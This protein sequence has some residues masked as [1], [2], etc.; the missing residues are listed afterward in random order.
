MSD[1]LKAVQFMISTANN[2]IHGYDQTNRNS[3]DYDCSSL[4][5]TALY[6]A[7][8]KVS[9]YSWTGNLL[10]QLKSCGFTECKAPWQAGDV[11][12]NVKHH[13]CMSIN[14][15]QIVHASI[16]ELGKATGGKTGDQTGKEICIR[17]YYEYSKGWDY[18]LRYVGSNT[19][20]NVEKTIE[21]LAREVIM[22]YWGNGSLRI[23][24]LVR[25]G[26][27]PNEVQKAVNNLLSG[28]TLK[29][30]SEIAREVINGVWG[31][32]SDRKNKLIKA[33]YDYDKIQ[34]LVNEML[35]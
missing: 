28:K 26:Y 7:G 30:D 8:F 5:G 3:P 4:V 18:H 21:T 23:S 22:G 11:H 17:D 32:G 27:N 34:K 16:N 31:N 33:G 15:S 1:I 13:V 6:E 24:N 25:A 12:L 14:P 10:E 19:G 9:P 29:S 20:T 2:D 35:S